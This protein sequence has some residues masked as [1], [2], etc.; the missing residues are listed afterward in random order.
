MGHGIKPLVVASALYFANASM[1][2]KIA[3][4]EELPAEFAGIRTGKPVVVD[5]LTWFGTAL[6][7]PLPMMLAHAALTA[8]ALRGEKAGRLG[9]KGLTA[10]GALFTIG[11]LGEPITYRA[12]RPRTVDPLKAALI[13][14]NIVFPILMA[15][16]GA[17]ELARAGQAQDTQVRT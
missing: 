14:G 15:L 10:L 2:A 3:L 4:D 5:F 16:F 9:V 8:L 7:P 12:L 11:M 17:R 13:T 1:G 6:S